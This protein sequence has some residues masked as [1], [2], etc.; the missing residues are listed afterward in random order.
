MS[1]SRFTGFV[2]GFVLIV[3]GVG[4]V[5]YGSIIPEDITIH[6][7]RLR[8]SV[9]DTT[10]I[11]NMSG[12]VAVFIGVASIMFWILTRKKNQNPKNILTDLPR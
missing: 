11:F 6:P 2:V 8:P 4:L 3:V 9:T 7:S 5:L 1:L 12:L 10:N